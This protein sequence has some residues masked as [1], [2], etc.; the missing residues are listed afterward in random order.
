VCCHGPNG[1]C[2]MLTWNCPSPKRVDPK[3][4]GVE[5]LPAL[6]LTDIT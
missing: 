4:I 3:T 5:E 1:T 2:N 6:G